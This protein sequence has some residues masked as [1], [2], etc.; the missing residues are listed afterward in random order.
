[1]TLLLGKYDV[2]EAIQTDQLRSR[3]PGDSKSG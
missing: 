1:M 2:P 3:N